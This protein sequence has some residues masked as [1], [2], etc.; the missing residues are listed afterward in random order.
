MTKEKCKTLSFRLD[1]GEYEILKAACED[2][3]IS[4]SDYFR[5]MLRIPLAADGIEPPGRFI[6][7]D[8]RTF[9]A[10]HK[11]LVKWGYHYNQAVRSLNSIAL[12]MRNGSLEEEWFAETLGKIDGEL[13]RVNAGRD[14]LEKAIRELDEKTSLRR[15]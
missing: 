4:Q 7:L 12:H 10:L 14:A 15:P 3:N 1:E 2:L 9:S 13:E 11:E 8:T 6:V 5:H